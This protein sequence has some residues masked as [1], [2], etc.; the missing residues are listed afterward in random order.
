MAAQLPVVGDIFAVVG[1]GL[2][3]DD[4]VD[5]VLLHVEAQ[6][7]ERCEVTH[8]FMCLVSDRKDSERR[9]Q[10]QINL[11]LPSRILSYPKIVKG[12]SSGK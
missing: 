8:G 4:G 7:L 3:D 2:G 6:S 1:I 5:A 9:E 10:W 11:T 12:E